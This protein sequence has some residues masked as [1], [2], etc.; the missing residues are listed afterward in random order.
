[1]HLYEMTASVAMQHVPEQQQRG[2]S[3]CVLVPNSYSTQ[4]N[5]GHNRQQNVITKPEV[6][7]Q[8]LCSAAKSSALVE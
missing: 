5:H 2:D 8:V 7:Q 1:M 4:L 6:G 3:H